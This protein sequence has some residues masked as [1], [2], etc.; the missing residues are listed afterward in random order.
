[1][2]RTGIDREREQANGEGD[3]RRKETMP[4][5]RPNPKDTPKV[6]DWPPTVCFL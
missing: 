2:E 4:I 6:C 1:M 3:A 5:N